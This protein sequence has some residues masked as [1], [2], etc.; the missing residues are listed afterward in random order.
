MSSTTKRKSFAT[1]DGVFQISDQYILPVEPGRGMGE[2]EIVYVQP[3]VIIM[4][5]DDYINLNRDSTISI[6]PGMNIRVADNDTLRYYLYNSQYV[7]PAPKPP[8]IKNP[9]NIIIRSSANFSM[10]VQAAEI[11]QVTAD[12]LDSSNKT[13][14]SEDIT[15]LGLGSGELW[16]FAWKWNATTLQLSDDKS[17]I[18][19]AE[20]E[21]GAGIALSEPA[22]LLRCR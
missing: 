19:D 6:G 7:V 2:M 18:M 11:R 22:L 15:A 1:I 12:I 4:V 17:L 16:V 13:V 8:L 14:F 20:R 9:S 3:N 10:I 5:N 21:L